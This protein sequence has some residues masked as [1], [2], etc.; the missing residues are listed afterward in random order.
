[1]P[2]DCP[3]FDREITVSDFLKAMTHVLGVTVVREEPLPNHAELPEKMRSLGER[4]GMRM[5][6]GRL[7]VQYSM[8]GVF[9]R[10]GQTVNHYNYLD[11]ALTRR[12]ETTME[13]EVKAPPANAATPSDVPPAIA[14]PVVPSPAATPPAAKGKVASRKKPVTK[15]IAKAV[16]SAKK[17]PAKTGAKKVGP[18]Q[19]VKKG[20][21]KKAAP[22]KGAKKAAPKKTVK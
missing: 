21:A 4:Q 3:A 1:K 5:D 2:G 6:N 15:A 8:K 11:T 19:A 22:K 12:K 16:K 14:P 13:P 10:Q 18:K 20:P 17:T 9:I 7:V